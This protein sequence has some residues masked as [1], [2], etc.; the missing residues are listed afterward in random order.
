LLLHA[1][2]A[3]IG[4]DASSAILMSGKFEIECAVC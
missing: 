3:A 4:H 1:I 2:I